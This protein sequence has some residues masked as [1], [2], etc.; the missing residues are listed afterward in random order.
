MH[1]SIMHSDIDNQNSFQKWNIFKPNVDKP[2]SIGFF[3]IRQ[4]SLNFFFRVIEISISSLVHGTS[5][6]IST[7][8]K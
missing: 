7:N 6:E 5:M 4:L 8:F 1:G 3:Q 2:H